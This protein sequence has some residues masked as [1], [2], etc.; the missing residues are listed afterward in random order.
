MRDASFAATRSCPHNACRRHT[1]P[2]ELIEQGRS[3]RMLLENLASKG[4]CP[5]FSTQVVFERTWRLE[6]RH[7]RVLFNPVHLAIILVGSNIM[8]MQ[9][10]GSG[11]S[12]SGPIDSPKEF[13]GK[14]L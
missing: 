5:L 11:A 12:T 9:Y 7:I 13:I 8:L 3:V 1:L 6:F 2:Q 4:R 14:R 10:Y